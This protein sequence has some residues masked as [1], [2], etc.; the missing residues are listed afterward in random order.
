MAPVPAMS[1]PVC[2]IENVSGSKLRT[3]P[4]AKKI[5]ENISQPLVVVSIVGQYRTGK[6]Y[7]MNTLAGVKSGGFALGH[8]V[9][10]KTKGI[11]MW[12]VPHPTR[13]D[14]MLVL[15]DTEGLA[16]VGKGDKRNDEQLFSLSVLL[17]SV[18]V[19]NSTGTIDQ[20]AMDKLYCTA[21]LCE[22]IVDRASNQTDEPDGVK[23][24]GDGELVPLF[25][26]AVRD[27]FLKV[28]MNG[29]SVSEDDYLEESL[30]SITPVKS[31]KTEQ[32]NNKR[33]TLRKRFP[34]RKCFLFENPFKK[35]SD[36]MEQ[37]LQKKLQPGFVAK[38]RSF[39]QFIFENSEAKTLSGG[40]VLTG[41][42]L[43]HLVDSYIRVVTSHNVSVLE[44][45]MNNIFIEHNKS[46][47]QSAINVYLEEMK[48][49]FVDSKKEFQHLHEI[50]KEKA[51]RLYKENPFTS[52]ETSGT[53]ELL[54]TIKNH[55][56]EIWKDREASSHKKCKDLIRCLSEELTKAIE[57]KKY[58][59]AGGHKKFVQDKE[60]LIKKYNM[61]PQ[62]GVKAEEVLQQF[63]K[64]LEDVEMMIIQCDKA[65]S[66]KPKRP[67][68]RSDFNGLAKYIC[69]YRL[70]S[71][72][73][74]RVLIQLFGFAGHG[75]SSF[76]NSCSFVIKNEPYGNLAGEAKTDGGKTIDRR[77][78]NLTKYITIVDNRGFVRM[79]SSESWEVYA[80][81]C[82]CVPLN[83]YVIWDRNPDERLKQLTNEETLPDL[84]VPVFVYS[85]EQD[86][87]TEES[88]KIK[89]FLKNAQKLT[90]ILPFI[91]LTKKLSGNPQVLDKK[92][93]Q[94]GMEKVYALE[95]YTMSDHVAVRGKHT[96]ILNFFA[97]VLEYVD[98]LYKG[99]EP[100]KQKILERKEFLRYMAFK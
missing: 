27:F 48:S 69:S 42:L 75:K 84:M 8:T 45:E 66:E 87:N 2:L 3:N 17:S 20:D 11:W 4:Q 43:G 35:E 28:E 61:K 6:S 60:D 47:L 25:V 85:S 56:D 22:Y 98:F 24:L 79:N 16:D 97:D 62:K 54:K 32:K 63:V 70:E 100:S 91:I 14:H 74:H 10:A 82:N 80:Q 34:K 59:V 58:H 88:E 83:Q 65:K 77:G 1:S 72:G 36:A 46:T 78:Y 29:R 39:C 76:V 40:H 49:K 5:L 71:K 64:S 18:L 52:K 41:V 38:T 68:D 51:L 12:C 23:D 92:F 81:L 21:E 13:K 50:S 90:G 7:L 53:D 19:Y 33:E 94:M 95:N 89:E 67:R 86:L 15:L 44:N 26:W 55:G 30:K 93:K 37:G 96:E 99:A 57:E 9:E 73:Y 31:M